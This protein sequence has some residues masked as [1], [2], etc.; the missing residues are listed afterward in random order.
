MSRHRPDQHGGIA[1]FLCIPVT[2]VDPENE[3]GIAL[4][5]TEG[6]RQNVNDRQ[7][8]P[9]RR[10]RHR[11]DQ[12]GGIATLVGAGQLHRRHARRHR[13]DQHGGIAT[14][15]A[16]MKRVQARPSRHR[17]DQHGGIATRPPVAAR[18]RA[19]CRHRPDQHGGIATFW[20]RCSS[21]M[22]LLMAVGIA[23]ISTE[24]LR[25]VVLLPPLCGHQSRHRP[26]QHG[27][28]GTLGAPTFACICSLR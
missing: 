1:T 28:I 20:C 9:E 24:G 5:S 3:V 27:G 13:P 7:Q 23:L 8:A 14:A 19:P 26:D 16:V 10:R 18:P 4:I 17:P 12:H 15:E 21:G 25:P 6:L 22:P 2:D 11:P